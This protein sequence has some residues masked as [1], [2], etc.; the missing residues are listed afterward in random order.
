MKRK[1]ILILIIVLSIF[2]LSN[3]FG[4]EIDITIYNNKGIKEYSDTYIVNSEGLIFLPIIGKLYVKDM[5]ESEIS[6]KIREKL[7][8][9]YFINPAVSVGIKSNYFTINGMVKKPGRYSF[10]RKIML[11]DA[12][13]LAE[14][15]REGADTVNVK[16]ISQNDEKVVNYYQFTKIGDFKQ[17]VEIKPGDIITFEEF[18]F[19]YVIGEVSNEFKTYYSPEIDIKELIVEA[20][21]TGRSALNHARILRKENEEFKNIR[22][23]L[24]TLFRRGRNSEIAINLLPG[25]VLFIPKNRGLRLESLFKTA[26]EIADIFTSLH[27]IKYL[28]REIF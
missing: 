5:D 17:N 3:Q 6:R 9:D 2:C 28:P 26:G 25:D 27:T 16:I 15:L 24:E 13:G 7:H 10:N 8:P 21:Y 23:N 14:G 1:I 12:I 22:I 20:G 19:I 11:S 18:D 4:T